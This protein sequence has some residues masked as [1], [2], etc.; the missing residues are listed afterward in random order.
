MTARTATYVTTHEVT[1]DARR[2]S[3]P[4][5]DQRV[6][7]VVYFVGKTPTREE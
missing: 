3:K 6:L 1:F 4:H 7:R 2:F 5:S